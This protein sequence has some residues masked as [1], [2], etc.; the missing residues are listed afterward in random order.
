MFAD[1]LP[2]TVICK[3]LG[4]PY[5]DR[6][7]FRAWSEAAVALTAFSP[8]EALEARINLVTSQHAGVVMPPTVRRDKPLEVFTSVG[9]PVHD[10]L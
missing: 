7:G 3:L 2:I 10:N 4:V 9:A 1:P 6:D 5:A 8:D